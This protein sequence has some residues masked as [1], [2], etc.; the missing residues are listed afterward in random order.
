MIIEALSKSQN[1]N[2]SFLVY[3]FMNSAFLTSVCVWGGLE[4]MIF[5]QYEHSHYTSVLAPP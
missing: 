3:T 5:K 1:L 2:I 4:T